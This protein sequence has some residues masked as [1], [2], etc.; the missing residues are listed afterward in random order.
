MGKDELK[1]EIE[2]LKAQRDK[3][4]EEIQAFEANL[5]ATVPDLPI[6]KEVLDKQLEELKTT[7]SGISENVNKINATFDEL[8]VIPQG[9][10]ASKSE[11]VKVAHQTVVQN[12]KEIDG[13]LEQLEEYR[14]EVFGET[15]DDQ[16]GLSQ[17]FN[18]LHKKIKD[19]HGVWTEETDAL[20]KRIEGLLP[21]ATATGLAKAYQDQRK[22]YTAPYWIWA[23][24]FVLTMSFMIGFSIINLQEVN[25]IDEAMTTIIS[26]LPFLVP[27]IW[28]AVF[29]SKQ[30]SQ[31]KRLE[32]EYAF[33]EA[34][35]KSYESSRREIEKLNEGGEKETLS[36]ELLSTMVKMTG[37]NPSETLQSKSHEEKPPSAFDLFKIKMLG[38]LTGDKNS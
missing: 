10:T 22:K 4:S 18:A 3:I 21:G 11:E 23:T 34:L 36:K 20:I 9:K 7:V 13:I 8:F 15:E 30:Q 19:D 12:K 2:A 28:L 29:A 26:R 25:S 17:K 38:R 33:K 32:Q 37:E 14:D 16:R 35:A 31:N 24:A 5:I 27:A 6:T 1:Q